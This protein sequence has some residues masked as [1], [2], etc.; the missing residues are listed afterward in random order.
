MSASPVLTLREAALADRAGL[1]ARHPE[2]FRRVTA[3]RV[4]TVLLIAAAL[5]LLVFGLWRL[6]FS[7]GRIAGGFGQLLQFLGLMLPP[8][9]GTTSRALLILRGLAETLAIAF[10]GTL[11]AA[12]IAFPLS[13]LAARNT[14]AGR[15]VHFL[16]RRTLDSIRGVDALIWALIWVSVVGLGPF[17]GV[18]A[19]ATG[20]IGTFGKLF[21]EAIEAADR[22]AVEGVTSAGGGKLAGIR[23]GVLPAVLP[24][25]AGHVLYMFESNTRSSTIIGIV[26]AG[27]IGLM[28][29]EMIRTLEWGVVSFIVLLILVAVAVI[30]AISGR[31][32][33]AL[34]G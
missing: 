13:F 30:D 23:F 12:G 19:I 21:S 34:A 7:P 33:A 3:A 15:L 8:D 29:S 11:L 2:V 14:S 4:R 18:L 27:G 22:R 5:G 31:L 16:S 25:M 32:R 10:L 6:E 20:D 28:L 9:P 1:A 17:A 26:G 24:V